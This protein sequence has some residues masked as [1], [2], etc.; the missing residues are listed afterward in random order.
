MFLDV[1]AIVG[2]AARSNAGLSHQLKTD[3]PTQVIWD[4]SLLHNS[5]SNTL[6]L[7][8]QLFRPMIDV[9]HNVWDDLSIPSSFHLLERK[10]RPCPSN[11]YPAGAAQSTGNDITSSNTHGSEMFVYLNACLTCL[12]LLL[13]MSPPFWL[14][15][16]CLTL[17]SSSLKHKHRCY[18]TDSVHRS[19]WPADVSVT[20]LSRPGWVWWDK[21]AARFLGWF[22]SLLCC[23]SV[24][25]WQCEEHLGYHLQNSTAVPSPGYKLKSI[26]KSEFI[27]PQL[28]DVWIISR[29]VYRDVQMMYIIDD[30]DI[31]KNKDIK[32]CFK[33]HQTSYNRKLLLIVHFGAAESDSNHMLICCSIIIGGKLLIMVLIINV[34]ISF[35]CSIFCGNIFFLFF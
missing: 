25:S 34:K 11:I 8:I 21:R 27:T 9:Y 12:D 32:I 10:A 5:Q 20:S 3:L 4:L 26:S 22:V 6:M 35:C 2:Y 15:S 17:S 16:D 30:I 31:T 24:S 29:M 19:A 23:S 14:S 7:N 1:L 33:W 28:S 13:L 18:S